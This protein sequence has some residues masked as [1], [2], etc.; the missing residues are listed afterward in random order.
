MHPEGMRPQLHRTGTVSTGLGFR[1]T[2]KVAPFK[3]VRFLLIR[4]SQGTVRFVS[5]RYSQVTR[6]GHMGQDQAGQSAGEV[7]RK[8]GQKPTVASGNV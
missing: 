6:Q 7:C 2:R 1:S 5:I 8:R 3:C 4:Y